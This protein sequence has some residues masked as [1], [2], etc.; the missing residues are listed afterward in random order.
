MDGITGRTSDRYVTWVFEEGSF[1]PCARLTETSKESIVADYLGTPTQMYDDKGKKTWSAEL[2]I[3]GRIRTFDSRSLKDC[4]F[5]YQG[6]YEDAETGRYY[7]RFRY[8][9]PEEGIYLSQDPIGLRGGIKVYGYVKNTNVWTDVMG[10]KGCEV[11]AGDG[12]THDIVL[13]VSKK[14]Y[15]ETTKHI[16]D[17]IK[18]GKPSIV[19]IDRLNASKRRA[20]SL[21]GIPTQKNKDRD[22][23]PM[24]MFK[25]GGKNA[26]VRHINPGDNRGA[27]SSIGSALE[28][29]DDDTRVKIVITD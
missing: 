5:R 9:L 27:G 22:E 7:N 13:E 1:V 12:K 29:F 25:E 24:A 17:A 16:E 19:T 23:W 14:E 4:P 11:K 26:S 15:P 21:K 6:Q 10:L 3:Y 20:E 18:A 28:G 2:D 8:Y